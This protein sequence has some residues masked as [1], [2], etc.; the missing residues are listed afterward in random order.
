MAD[1]CRRHL[2]SEK[3]WFGL[4]CET[5]LQLVT[6]FGFACR[7]TEIELGLGVRGS[8]LVPYALHFILTE[9]NTKN[10]RG[11]K[12]SS[13]FHSLLVTTSSAEMGL[14]TN[15]QCFSGITGQNCQMRQDWCSCEIPFFASLRMSRGIRLAATHSSSVCDWK[16]WNRY[17]KETYKSSNFA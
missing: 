3:G 15:F 17:V 2:E 8:L 11:N 16:L 6:Q 1:E 13:S 10:F 5:W 14:S 9:L 12:W 7:H 4:R